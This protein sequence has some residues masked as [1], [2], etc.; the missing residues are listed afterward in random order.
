MDIFQWPMKLIVWGGREEGEQLG[1][2]DKTCL[3]HL[4]IFN[5]YLL[6]HRRWQEYKEKGDG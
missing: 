6:G 3:P 5:S 4:A 1:H 2:L